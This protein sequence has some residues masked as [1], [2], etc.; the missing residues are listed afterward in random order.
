M[1]GD[2]LG[3]SEQIEATASEELPG[4]ESTSEEPAPEDDGEVAR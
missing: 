3:E 4:E 2:E 1:E